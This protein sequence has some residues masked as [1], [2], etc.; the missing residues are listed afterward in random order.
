MARTAALS[1]ATAHFPSAC[2]SKVAS[3]LVAFRLSLVAQPLANAGWHTFLLLPFYS[4]TAVHFG[5]IG[6]GPNPSKK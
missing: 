5:R 2:Q 4:L 1:L 6:A 3:I